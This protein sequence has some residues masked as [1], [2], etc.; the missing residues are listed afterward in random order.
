MGADGSNPTRLTDNPA[1]DR[2]PDWQPLA[3]QPLACTITGTE[4]P[5]SLLGTAGDDVI[6]G[7]GGSDTIDG[8][9]DTIHA[10]AGTDFANGGDGK[11]VPFRGEGNDFL[12]VQDAVSANDT[13]DEQGGA[14]DHCA[15]DQGDTKANCEYGN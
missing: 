2:Y 15:R 4:G 14:A 8:G 13:V 12:N 11:D 3:G 6:C 10:D 1:Q 5:D 7:L 9:N